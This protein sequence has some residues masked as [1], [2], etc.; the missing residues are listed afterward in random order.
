MEA[1]RLGG[2]EVWLA[3]LNPEVYAMIRRSPLGEVLGTQRM[4]FNLEI[5]VERFRERR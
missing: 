4:M 3:G 1:W 2:V 5:A